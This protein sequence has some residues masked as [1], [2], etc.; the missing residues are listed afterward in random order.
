MSEGTQTATKYSCRPVQSGTSILLGPVQ[1]SPSHL[2]HTSTAVR[3][4]G[5]R[6]FMHV[7]TSTRQKSYVKLNRSQRRGALAC[8]AADQV[9]GAGL[10]VR[11]GEAIVLFGWP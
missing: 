2:Q 3:L 11:N 4:S 6:V 9:R 1:R 8:G 7:R 5:R 10:Q